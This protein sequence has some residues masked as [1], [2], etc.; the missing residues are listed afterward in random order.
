MKMAFQDVIEAAQA[1]WAAH[2]IFA[3]KKHGSLQICADCWK[4]NNLTHLESYFILRMDEFIASLEEATVFS[5]L[6]TES[7]YWQVKI[8]E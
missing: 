7:G 8:E 1:E 4:L 5:T 6:N 3:T 2:I